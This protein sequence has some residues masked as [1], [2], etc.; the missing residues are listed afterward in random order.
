MLTFPVDH[1]Q[2]SCSH[3]SFWLS[4]SSTYVLVMKVLFSTVELMKSD[5]F[6][7]TSPNEL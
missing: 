7:E 3:S 5:K 4:D 2:Y 6:L 1:L